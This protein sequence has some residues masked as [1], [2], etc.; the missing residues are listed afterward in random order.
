MNFLNV[1]DIPD[2]LQS[3]KFPEPSCEEVSCASFITVAVLHLNKKSYQL[4]RFLF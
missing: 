1:V 4:V 2:L 3:V